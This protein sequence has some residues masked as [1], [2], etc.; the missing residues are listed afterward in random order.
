MFWEKS[1]DDEWLRLHEENREGSR[2]DAMQSLEEMKLPMALELPSA[3]HGL[4]S[5]A[6]DQYART[7]KQL[8]EAYPAIHQFFAYAQWVLWASCWEGAHWFRRS[9]DTGVIRNTATMRA[10]CTPK[11]YAESEGWA[12]SAYDKMSELQFGKKFSTVL[13]RFGYAMQPS[14]SSV[15][16]AMRLNW[17]W[18][19]SDGNLSR[20]EFL[21]ALHEASEASS[22]ANG[23]YMWSESEKLVIESIADPT[24]NP[25]AS[26]ARKV[27]AKR[28]ATAR[29]S[30][31]RAMKQQVFEWCDTNM[32]D[33]P[34]MDT[35]ASQVAGVVVPVAWRTVRDWMTEWKKLRSA[36]TA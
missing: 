35:A 29:H 15:L 27:L 8:K 36:G 34:S 21:E 20:P 14:D 24:D 26:M 18:R 5:R 3:I 25:A 13:E 1:V 23:L 31:N 22:L 30:E 7:H 12:Y 9:I 4:H 2:K 28:A 16:T 10:L 6:N 32:A 17:L 19:A 11:G 33:T